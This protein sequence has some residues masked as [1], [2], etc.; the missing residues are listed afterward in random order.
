LI[1][2]NIGEAEKHR[3]NNV[4]APAIP[5]PYPAFDT[6]FLQPEIFDTRSLW[7]RT[8]CAENEPSP[9]HTSKLPVNIRHSFIRVPFVDGSHSPFPG[10]L[11]PPQ[12]YPIFV[13][14]QWDFVIAGGGRVYEYTDRSSR[15]FS[16]RPYIQ[17]NL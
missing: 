4:G 6:A 5:A 7:R 12:Q 3:A 1:I 8:A 10:G 11:G 2:T 17:G 16:P 13:A 14:T 15:F 9:K